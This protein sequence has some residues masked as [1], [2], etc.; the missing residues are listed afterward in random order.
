[1]ALKRLISINVSTF[2]LL[3]SNSAILSSLNLAYN[4]QD[5]HMGNMRHGSCSHSP[6]DTLH[7]E[8]LVASSLENSY[9]HT[10]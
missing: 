6:S 8:I 2:N 4:G 1:M 7:L 10:Q 5:L 9:E 3:I